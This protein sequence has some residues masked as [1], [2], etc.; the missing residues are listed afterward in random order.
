MTPITSFEF[1]AGIAVGKLVFGALF[2]SPLF[3]SLALTL[4]A[5]AVGFIY[6]TDGVTGILKLAH[7]LRADV[8]ARP[9]FSKGVGVGIIAAFIVFGICR[10]HFKASR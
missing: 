1:L 2:A 7:L 8:L 5:I 4:G 6:A 10:R 3:R 9:D